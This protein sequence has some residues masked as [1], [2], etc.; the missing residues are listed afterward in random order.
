ML[1]KRLAEIEEKFQ[2]F[3]A[4]LNLNQTQSKGKGRGK[5]SV[6]QTEDL[7]QQVDKEASK[8][9]RSFLDCERSSTSSQSSFPKPTA[10]A[11]TIL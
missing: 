5:R 10:P 3:Q 2:Q 7:A 9:L 8:R 11:G 4:N 6:I 1:E